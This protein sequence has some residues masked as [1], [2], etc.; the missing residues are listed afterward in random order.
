MVDGHVL[1]GGPRPCQVQGRLVDPQGAQRATER[2]ASRPPPR[3]RAIH[4][5]HLRPH[6]VPGHDGPREG[7]SLEGHR[8]GGREPARHAVGRPRYGV[9]LGHDQWHPQQHRSQGRRQSGIATDG[10]HDGGPSS[11]H[12]AERPAD[13]HGE[14]RNRFQVGP[15]EPALDPAT[16][17]KRQLEPGRGH[18]ASLDAAP[19]A[20]VVD[21]FGG[22]SPFH[23]G[24]T[25]SQ[26]GQ[27]V[28][29]CRQVP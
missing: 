17:Q 24:S 29:G 26:G 25:D 8:G 2:V 23:Q 9:R 18:E 12:Q 4:G 3:R 1:T 16:G 21:G 5:E 7:R 28:P 6:G 20:D 11:G 10:E 27:H 19:R 22:M 14:P 15:A 13:G